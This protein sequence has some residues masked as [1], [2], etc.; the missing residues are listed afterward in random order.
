MLDPLL[1][2]GKFTINTN[3]VTGVVD[4]EISKMLASFIEND[5][6]LVEGD[7]DSN[8]QPVDY[9]AGNFKGEQLTKI[10]DWLLTNYYKLIV[11]MFPL[12]LKE[13]NKPKPKLR[14]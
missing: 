10:Y 1:N 5:L 2:S 11:I 12:L 9:I 6:L 13:H 3:G 7:P 8:F 14:E 4:Q